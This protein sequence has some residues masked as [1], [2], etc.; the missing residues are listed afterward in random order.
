MSTGQWT[1]WQKGYRHGAIMIWPPESVRAEINP[2]RARYCSIA[3]SYCETHISLTQPLLRPL[4]AANWTRLE[5][6]VAG[7]QP[8][9]IHYGPLRTWSEGRIIYFAIEP[10]E[11]ILD[12]RDVLHQT[13][14]FDLDRP[15]TEGFVPHM[16][17]QEGY[18]EGTEGADVVDAE[19]GRAR[20]HE[21]KGTLTGGSFIC[22]RLTYL[23]PDPR[24]HFEVVRTLSFANESEG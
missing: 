22:T 7:F 6:I 17:I 13:G 4:D 2:L 14:L 18:A 21:L 3:H 16:T 12:I 11:T 8:F 5:Q 15:F 19:Q 10:A 20:Y 1:E 23:V 24:F 9:T